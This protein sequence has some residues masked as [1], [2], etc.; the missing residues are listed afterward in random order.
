VRYYPTLLICM[1]EQKENYHNNT[2]IWIN[3]RFP[4]K[5]AE[6]YVC[7]FILRR[8]CSIIL[9]IYRIEVSIEFIVL[10]QWKLH[11]KVNCTVHTCSLSCEPPSIKRNR[12]NNYWKLKLAQNSRTN[13]GA[14]NKSLTSFHANFHGYWN[15]N[16]F[17]IA[18]FN[19]QK[20]WRHWRV[21]NDVVTKRKRAK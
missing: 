21:C 5:R 14:T 10:A 18:I 6:R 19:L 12:R 17:L 2:K 16:G 3:F 1:E 8:W 13:Y 15:E 11:L 7:A 20:W 4:S 9:K